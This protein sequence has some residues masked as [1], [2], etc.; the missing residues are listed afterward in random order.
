MVNVVVFL[1]NGDTEVA[2]RQLRN[3]MENQGVLRAIRRSA[4]FVPKA[5]KRRDKSGRAK[6]RRIKAGM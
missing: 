2:L 1:L 6:A 5:E 3:S 4:Y